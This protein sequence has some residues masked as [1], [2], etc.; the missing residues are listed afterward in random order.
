MRAGPAL[1]SEVSFKEED[2]FYRNAIEHF[3]SHVYYLGVE[4]ENKDKSH[5]DGITF[6]GETHLRFAQGYQT[7][8]NE[9]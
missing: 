4:Q 5:S 7:P 1:D 3:E 6:V 9:G 2:I 8:D